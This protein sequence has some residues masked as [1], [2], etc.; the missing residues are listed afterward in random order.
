M[1]IPRKYIGLVSAGILFG[2][3]IG[4]L[5]FRSPALIFGIS[6]AGGAVGLILTFGN[7]MD[8]F[9]ALMGGVLCFMLVLYTI[10]I[11]MLAIFFGLIG[12][13]LGVLFLPLMRPPDEVQTRGTG[14]A[15]DPAT[16][17]QIASEP[18]M[19]E[20][21]HAQ[22]LPPNSR[23]NP[24]SPEIPIEDVTPGATV[25]TCAPC[26]G[27]V[28]F[29]VGRLT[30][31]CRE[32][33]TEYVQRVTDQQYVPV[34]ILPN[35]ICLCCIPA[36]PLVTSPGGEIRYCSKS[37]S[38]YVRLP[39]RGYIRECDIE[40]IGHCSCCTPPNPLV[41]DSQGAAHCANHP[42]EFYTRRRMGGWRRA[43]STGQANVD[44]RDID[45]A[46]QR[47]SAGMLPGGIFTVENQ[48][49]EQI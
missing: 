31:C 46:L 32:C 16:N 18:G 35:G 43:S 41:Y 20:F 34:A 44:I 24:I 17:P 27:T 13:I 21:Q 22:H 10:R 33:A 2:A 48:N 40:H 47:G 5:V 3:A 1:H 36:R 9:H 11:P 12:A 38:A 7:W 26:G 45:Q 28:T 30:Y 6:I 14:G 15:P 42:N 29:E 23:M 49:R 4:M 19:E 37:R 39:E 8:L 25:A